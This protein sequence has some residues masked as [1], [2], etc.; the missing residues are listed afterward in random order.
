MDHSGDRVMVTGANYAA[1]NGEYEL[2]DYVRAGY[3]PIYK[4]KGWSRYIFW[5]SSPGYGWS[6]G[7]SAKYT[8]FF[9]NS[10]GE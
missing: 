6:I 4:K 10:Y 5:Q 2:I 7:P 1:C 3:R 8:N 9:H